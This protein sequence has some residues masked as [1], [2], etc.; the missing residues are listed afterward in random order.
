MGRRKVVT[1]RA[2]QL[3]S[4]GIWTSQLDDLPAARAQEIAAELETLGFGTLWFGEAFGREALTQA[5]LFLAGTTS[6]CYRYRN[7]EHLR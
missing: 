7:R 2:L 4:T 5:G 6:H 3:G 1:H